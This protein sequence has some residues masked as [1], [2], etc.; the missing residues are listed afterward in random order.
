MKTIKLDMKYFHQ[1][2]LNS[3]I[4]DFIKFTNLDNNF[5]K[6]DIDIDIL[7]KKILNGIEIKNFKK[8][9]KIFKI[10]NLKKKKS[11][12]YNLLN[13][14]LKKKNILLKNNDN[15]EKKINNKFYYSNMNLFKINKNLYLDLK[16]ERF[17]NYRP[18]EKLYI[19]NNILIVSQN[20]LD[21]IDKIKNNNNTQNINYRYIFCDNNL[22]KIQISTKTILIL[23]PIYSIDLINE[24][25]KKL[26]K[27]IIIIK[28]NNDLNQYSYND[29][30]K[31]DFLIINC[32]IFNKKYIENNLLH[33]KTYFSKKTVI[34]K[35]IYLLK[36]K[37][38]LQTKTKFLHLFY[39][40]K[41]YFF[42]IN[43]ILN[44][45]S[46]NTFKL[47]YLL[48]AKINYCF[49]NKI[50][51]K[52]LSTC[53]L[54]NSYEK[55]KITKTIN[56]WKKILCYSY[57]LK[58]K[59]INK[60]LFFNFEDEKNLN[61][62]R[63]V[64]YFKFNN[65]QKQIE[66][67]VKVNNPN[68]INE[69]CSVINLKNLNNLIK[70][71]EYIK[72]FLKDLDNTDLHLEEDCSIC[73][74]KIKKNIIF[75]CGHNICLDC[76]YKLKIKNINCCPV[77]RRDFSDG[78]FFFQKDNENN[79]NFKIEYIINYL[80]N[81]NIAKIIIISSFKSF[82]SLLYKEIK[83][84]NFNVNY[85]YNRYSVGPLEK[86]NKNQKSIL[87]TTK[88]L[89]NDY[90]KFINCN[91]IILTDPFNN[92]NNIKKFESKII[93]SIKCKEEKI[94]LNYLIV[95]NSVEGKYYKNFIIN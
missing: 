86:F 33:Y 57:S 63:D 73:L 49:M 32:N 37:N 70:D 31:T 20:N 87:L 93:D 36:N 62:I 95:E 84:Q 77:C 59:I 90:V 47:I 7:K 66:K 3:I 10:Y 44:K 12:I 71:G 75:Y 80:S 5:I 61:I 35:L 78:K 65:N 28:K 8:I 45:L 23:S 38:I 55:Y 54:L 25:I 1:F 48:D 81:C 16:E 43:Y 74:N 6:I 56:Y 53:L 68:L 19:N 22:Q 94:N 67:I 26:N 52:I 76:F 21:L 89:C 69:Y 83:K 15:I 82:L 4:S 92:Y 64:K 11:K 51:N 72:K 18:N 34:N 42:D 24:K 88:N 39:W 13:N 79:L 14:N 50:N 58:K 9:I 41:I 27:N 17:I 2:N 40:N 85:F 60:Y 91:N 46:L 29:I 30:L